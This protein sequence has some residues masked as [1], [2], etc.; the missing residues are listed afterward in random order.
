MQGLD[1]EEQLAQKTDFL[2]QAFL[3]YGISGIPE[4]AVIPSKPFEYRNRLQFHRVPV[5]VE[6]E[7]PNRKSRTRSLN[8]AR[9]EESVCG[10]M[11][12]GASEIVPVKDCLTAAPVIRRSLSAGGIVPPVDMDRFCVYGKDSTLLIEG[13]NSCG[14][15]RVHQKDIKMDAGVFFQ[16]NGDLL[17]LL[18]DEILGTAESAKKSLPA[19]DFYCGV[20]TFAVFLQDVFDRIDLLEADKNA[21]RLARENICLKEARFFGQSDTVW[22]QNARK[23]MVYGFVAADPGRQGLSEAMRR[24]L[25]SNCEILCYVSCNPNALARDA[26]FLLDTGDNGGLKLESLSFYDFYPQ[27]KHIESLAVFRRS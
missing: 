3:C 4:I 23:N 9:K 1:Y 26:A 2:R 27:T 16:S 25:R 6:A 22:A 14:T 21:L 17:E 18:I 7:F 12:R 20:G 10:F 5:G 8:L 13:R 15:A 24:F 19:A 11:A